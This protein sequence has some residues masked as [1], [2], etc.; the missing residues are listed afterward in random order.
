MYSTNNASEGDAARG[1]FTHNATAYNICSHGGS[2]LPL[3]FALS[4]ATAI[5]N[6]AGLFV[7]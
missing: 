4:M 7:E 3:I 5:A 2:Q 6:T 1:W